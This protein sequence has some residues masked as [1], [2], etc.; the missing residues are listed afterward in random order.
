MIREDWSGV[1]VGNQLR[2]QKAGPNCGCY[3]FRSNSNGR[4]ECDF[5]KWGDQAFGLP[6]Q[7]PRVSLDG[8]KECDYPYANPLG[9][10]VLITNDVGLNRRRII[11]ALLLHEMC[12]SVSGSNAFV[13]SMSKFDELIRKVVETVKSSEDIMKNLHPLTQLQ[14]TRRF[15]SLTTME[16]LTEDECENILVVMLGKGS[17]A[18]SLGVRLV[19][20]ERMPDSPNVKFANCSGLEAYLA[21]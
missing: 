21:V 3:F 16:S 17:Y 19:E 14:V 10:R 9:E 11:A 4:G 1:I 5:F 2:V 8:V 12:V 7:V 13:C 18:H 15:G 6:K 20:I